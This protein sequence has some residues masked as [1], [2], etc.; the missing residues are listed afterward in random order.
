MNIT[1][2]PEGLKEQLR[3]HTA[4]AVNSAVHQARKK[5]GN[6]TS[7]ILTAVTAWLKREGHSG[8]ILTSHMV[9][10]ILKHTKES[11]QIQDRGL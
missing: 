7:T 2:S 11:S 6:D 4:Q 5:Y 3:T 9:S 10:D 8:F 1:W